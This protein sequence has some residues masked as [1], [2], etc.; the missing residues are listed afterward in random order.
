MSDVFVIAEAGVNHNGDPDMAIE[1][2]DAAAAANADA[3]KFQTFKATYLATTGAAKAEYQK[4]TT[5]TSESQF[6]MLEKLELSETLH[7]KIADRCREKKIRFLSTAFDPLSLRF[8]VE[9]M[10]LETLKIPSGEITNAPL[11]LQ[12]AQS[13]RD[14]IMSTGMSSLD[15]V[16]EALGVLAFGYMHADDKPPSPDA[17]RAAFVTAGDKLDGKVTLLHCTTEYP[18][19]FDDINLRA[20][21]TLAETFHL[22]VGLSDHSMGIAVPIAAAARGATIIEKHFTLDRGLPGPDHTA[23]LE[24]GELKD[25]VASIRAVEVALGNGIKESRSSEKKNINIVRK[26]LVA[27]RPISAG[28]RFAENNLGVMRPGGGA[29][30]M[31][32][33]NW[34]GRVADRNYAPGEMVGK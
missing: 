20:M 8:L 12:A 34:L 21:D 11:L 1:L 7:H 31:E 32:F 29:S 30:P 23:S 10:K 18:A 16:K 3:V 22:P 2:V 26:S 15:E 9:D 6:E 28:E 19:P 5:A 27:L 25:M 14:I 17:F 24:P 13:G 4:R 33:W